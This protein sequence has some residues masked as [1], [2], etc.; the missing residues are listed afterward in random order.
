MNAK[1]YLLLGPSLALAL[2]MAAPGPGLAKGGE[3][4]SWQPVASEKLIKLPAN[5]LKKSLD[6]DFAQSALSAAIQD[7]DGEIGLKGQTLED[8]RAAIEQAEGELAVELRH[9]FLAQ[10]REFITLMKRKADLRFRHMQTKQK[11]LERLL[12]KLG[13]EKGAMTPARVQLVAQQQEARNRFQ[14]SLARVDLSVLAA[15]AV[16]ESKYAQE[17]ATNMGA[18]ESLVAAIRHHPMNA[19]TQLAGNPATKGDF[20]RQMLA[21]TQAGMAI[22]DQEQNILGYMAKLVALD[23]MALSEQVMDT[24]LTDS[25]IPATASPASA[26][27]YFVN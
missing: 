21:D 3:A 9:Q 5:Y 10:K 14:G 27:K 7:A 12:K 4:P 17:Y 26:V 25:D 20:I 16:P 13:Q 23:A 19:G 6:H 22:L 18:V 2:A 24:E 1:R 8:L 15:S 11:T